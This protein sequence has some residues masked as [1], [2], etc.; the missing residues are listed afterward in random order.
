[1]KQERTMVI[2]GIL[3]L[4]LISWLGWS[5][6]QVP[7]SQILPSPRVPKPAIPTKIVEPSVNQRACE[8]SGGVWNACGSAC[9][10]TPDAVCIEVCVPYCECETS[11][12]CPGETSCTDFVEG[13]GVCG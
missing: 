9:R 3:G 8:Q 10:T 13:T 11:D 5:A 6:A 2:A 7:P 12:Q 1:M 4:I